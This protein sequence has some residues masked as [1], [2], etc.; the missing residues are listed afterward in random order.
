M[1]S[2]ACLQITTG[3]TNQSE[4]DL[5]HSFAFNHFLCSILTSSASNISI[6]FVGE[7]KVERCVEV[8]CKLYLQFLEQRLRDTFFISVDLCCP[9]T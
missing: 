7:M 9:P 5:S 6:H 4:V 3:C 2:A 1:I 8:I